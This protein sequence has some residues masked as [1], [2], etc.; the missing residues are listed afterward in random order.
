MALAALD[1]L[2]AIKAA[3][4]ST[5]LDRLDGLTVQDCGGWLRIATSGPTDLRSQVVVQLLPGAVVAPTTEVGPGSAPGDEVTRN[6]PPLSTTPGHVADGMRPARRSAR[7]RPSDL[8][9]GK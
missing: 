4:E 5:P 9:R 6:H 8:G 3:F 1:Q 7:G 2:A